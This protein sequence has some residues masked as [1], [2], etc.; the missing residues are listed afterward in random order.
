MKRAIL[1]LLVLLAPL[2]PAIA[3]ETFSDPKALVQSIYDGYRPGALRGD[4]AE[5]YSERLKGIAE[6]AQE[7]AKF[8]RTAGSEPAPAADPAFN[9]FLPDASALLFDLKVG[10]PAMLD[11]RAVITVTYH[12]FDQPRL[13][14]ISLVKEQDSWKVDDVASM[15]SDVPWL[16]SWALA[17]DPYAM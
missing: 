12:N 2:S 9:P 16:L 8:T 3:A 4:P 13:L 10:D 17:A 1:A 7:N 6:L 5:Y 14:A 15:G 11:D